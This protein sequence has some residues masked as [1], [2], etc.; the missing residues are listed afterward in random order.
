MIVYWYS[1]CILFVLSNVDAFF[2]AIPH[3][4]SIEC[5][6]C[7]KAKQVGKS[8]SHYSQPKTPNQVLYVKTIEDNDVDIVIGSGPAG[9]GKTMLACNIAIRDLKNGKYDKIVITRPVVPVEEDIGYL[10][11]NVN[12]KMDPW[13]I[14]IFDVF[15]D[16]YSQGTIN[17]MMHSGVIEMAPL[18]YMRGRTFKRSFIIADEMQ[19]SSPNQM[20][21]LMTR[22]G[23]SSKM[24]ITGDSEQ[25]DKK[26]SESGLA[27][28]MDRYEQYTFS[29]N[30]YSGIKIVRMTSVDILRSKVVSKVL[31]IYMNN[32]EV[33]KNEIRK[34]LPLPTTKSAIENRSKIRGNGDAALIP[35][36]HITKKY[37]DDVPFWGN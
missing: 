20:K 3:K 37:I 13:L 32:S 19:N 34:Q 25:S 7:M 6:I 26:T 17:T 8:F 2:I 21:M 12:K 28:F 33:K 16:F 14:P 24:V 1:L 31:D 15:L 11:G 22:I 18:T 9:T 23:E 36:H 30:T 29:N 35:I 10:P 4:G 27:D 5:R